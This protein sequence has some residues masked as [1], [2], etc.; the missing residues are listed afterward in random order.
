MH[1]TL[2]EWPSRD[3]NYLLRGV[4]VGLGHEGTD[5]LLRRSESLLGEFH[6]IQ[7]RQFCGPSL[8]L[9]HAGLGRSRRVEK[10][11]AQCRGSNR[12]KKADVHTPQGFL[13]MVLGL[14]AARDSPEA[15][16]SI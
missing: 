14:L 15:Q 12:P 1:W 6:C 9:L 16:G 7:L 10:Q 11:R 3:H 5:L 4:L 2:R 8:Q 13:A